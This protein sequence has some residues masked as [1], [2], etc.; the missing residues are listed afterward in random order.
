MFIS[1]SAFLFI[2]LGKPTPFM[3]KK[4]YLLLSFLLSFTFLSQAQSVIIGNNTFRGTDFY[5][6]FRVNTA[7][8]TAWSRYAYIYNAA[9]IDGL[10]HGDSITGLSFFRTG[11]DALRT[12]TNIRI[13]VR[14]SIFADFGTG[15]L[16]W[17]SESTST[18]MVKVFDGDARDL[19]STNPGWIFFPFNNPYGVDTTSGKENFEVLFE[20]TQN[21]RGNLI[22]WSYESNFAVPAFTS[23]N[24]S[25][26]QTGTGSPQDTVR[27]SNL[28]KPYLKIHIPQFDT[29]LRVNKIYSLGNA[30]LLMGTK[31]TIKAWVENEGKKTVYNQPVFLQVSGVNKDQ[32]TA[33]IDSIRP[34]ESKLVYFR[35]HELFNSGVETL[36]VYVNADGV[37]QSDSLK[38]QRDVN[39]NVY[40]HASRFET[41]GPGG[42]GFNAPLTG[43]FVAKFYVD[44]VQYMN[45]IKVDFSRANSTYMLGVWAVDANSGLPGRELYMSDTLTSVLGTN[46][47]RVNPKVKIDTAFFVGIR[48]PTT[49]NVGFTYQPELPLRRG[50]F[51]YTVPA[52]GT[53]WVE[54]NEYNEAFKFNIQPR[55]QVANDVGVLAIRKPIVSDT[56]EY[57]TD[58]IAPVVTV[59]NYGYANQ[60][61][62]FD[63]VCEVKNEFGQTIYQ[64][65]KTITLKSE[66]TAQITFDK[67]LSFIYVRNNTMKVYT[68]LPNDRVVDNDTLTR[69][70]Y[71]GILHDVYTEG[72][73]SPFENE[74]FRLNKDYVKP[75]A[76]LVNNG[77]R[78]KKN[79]GVMLRALKDGV[80]FYA[81]STR[82]NID[83]EGSLIQA[84]D[85]FLLTKEGRVEIQVFVYGIVDSFPI[86]DTARVFVNVIKSDD[87]GLLS[88]IRPTD[89]EV[90]HR[91][92]KFQPYVNVRNHGTEDQDSVSIICTIRDL[93]GR[94]W[95]ADTAMKF[96]TRISTTQEIFG[97]FTVPDTN[98]TYVA[99]FVVYN[100]EDQDA[101]NDTLRSTFFGKSKFD[102]GLTRFVKPIDAE[103]IEY[104]SGTYTPQVEVHNFGTNAAAENNWVW[105]EVQDEQGQFYF[106]SLLMAFPIPGDSTFTVQFTGFE[107]DQLGNYQLK[108]WVAAASDG[109]RSNDTISSNFAVVANQSIGIVRA[110][111]PL[112]SAHFEQ[113]KST[114]TPKVRVANTGLQAIQSNTDV[115]LLITFNKAI[116]LK[117]TVKFDG[118][119]VGRDTVL[120]YSSFTA[121]LRGEYEF[122]YVLKN[123]DDQVLNDDSLS[124]V[125]FV[126][127]RND[128]KA[129]QLLFPSVDTVLVAN[130]FYSLKASFINLG[131]SN[132]NNAFSVTM[133][134]FDGAA[135]IYNSNA[136]VTAEAGD[137][138]EVDFPAAFSPDRKTSYDYLVFSRLFDDQDVNNDTISGSFESKWSA[139]ITEVNGQRVSL[140]P[141]PS[142][143]IVD[144]QL[145]PGF[146][147]QRYSI[148]D[149]HGKELYSGK[150]EGQEMQLDLQ[151]L[152][153]GI[154][155]FVCQHK[156]GSAKL[157]F[158][159]S[160]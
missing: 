139:S 146:V 57:S 67:G 145:P 80:P 154:Y 6:P 82:V 113:N 156:S 129:Y 160:E 2:H 101:S 131:D 27:L 83:K 68:K 97:E 28:R 90:Y 50:V 35:N 159:L 128:I 92:S 15:P 89:M 144:V 46:I 79:I 53:N 141:N 133:Q 108:S 34:N 58:S 81:D 107:T 70:Y 8:D 4:T 71:V 148:M 76:R 1:V 40:S 51:Y 64:S 55:I 143:G 98:A 158:V 42:I 117:E 31:D 3:T 29:N 149:V 121:G 56:I 123:A 32:D 30:P 41:N 137:T 23:N 63:V 106:D 10:K 65:T 112:D 94:V 49:T 59:I 105:I 75:I 153:S 77:I 124:G 14:M 140:S 69:T 54:F 155:F 109:E 44:S 95:Y 125:Y 7:S 96:Y 150:V 36:N 87:I 134:I 136:S 152:P 157:R 18:G 21:Q 126:G 110:L 48:Q 114:I 17:T 85:S 25:K 104:E 135:M 22:P 62:P 37:P 24:E 60:N 19:V 130:E 9:S 116:V 73:F 102:L 103:Q 122:Q 38:I 78:D 47:L 88:I 147:S 20:Y 11:S 12:G 52:G 33:I 100:T 43:D 111:E 120:T 66:D 39:Y 127:R 61:A 93:S 86:N 115:E 119:G 132:Q 91:K 84:F 74:E 138:I 142:Q 72:F 151:A 45:Q 16:N 99:E 118:L 5:G 26:F 13:F